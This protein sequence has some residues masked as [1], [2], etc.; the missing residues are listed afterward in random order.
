VFWLTVAEV[1]LNKPGN[2]KSEI[3]LVTRNLSEM[4]V[5]KSEANKFLKY[6]RD[7][8]QVTLFLLIFLCKRAT[9]AFVI[10][11]KMGMF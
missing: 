1:Q 8:K 4:I 6:T 7:N 10:L 5:K 11:A 2:P 9:Y 3:R